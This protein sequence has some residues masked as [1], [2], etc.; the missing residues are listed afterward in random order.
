MDQL[1]HPHHIGKP[2]LWE[3]CGEKMEF[4]IKGTDPFDYP[5]RKINWIKIDHMTH[6]PSIS[7]HLH[8]SR[9]IRHLSMKG[10]TKT[11]ER[12]YRER[13]FSS[14]NGSMGIS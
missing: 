13:L 14:W 7:H 1:S 2:D 9:W 12:L 8:N 4:L 11:F 5:D 6:T 10:N 3:N